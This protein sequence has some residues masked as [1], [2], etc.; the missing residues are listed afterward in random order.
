MVDEFAEKFE[1]ASPYAYVLNN[2]I[3][4][5]DPDGR[6]TLHLQEV[7]VTSKASV[8][9]MYLPP[10]TFSPRPLNIPA[11]GA[12]SAVSPWVLAPVLVFIPANWGQTGEKELEDKLKVHLG[13]LIRDHLTKLTVD[14][15]VD[16]LEKIKIKNQKD[17]DFYKSPGGKVQADKDF[18]SLG[19]TDVKP[20]PGGRT[21]KLP[22]GTPINVRD[23]ST[24]G[25]PT[26]E[27]QRPGN[28]V[29]IRYDE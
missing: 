6:D 28:K 15:L 14:E 26:V 10:P 21:G 1:D 23:R 4:F 5:T 19:P 20:I 18:D 17:N 3:K 2:P 22:D 12:I 7:V 25:R 29:K 8:T 16:G 27:V 13:K 24:D 11:V 9:P